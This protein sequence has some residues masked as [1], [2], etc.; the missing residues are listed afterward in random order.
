MKGIRH[1]LKKEVVFGACPV[2]TPDFAARLA[3]RATCFASEVYLESGN[4][5]LCV[6]SLIGILAMDLRKGMRVTVC[7]EGVDEGEATA[8]IGALLQTEA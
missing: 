2:V 1:M 5:R 4:T 8:C 6:D 3:Q 7:A